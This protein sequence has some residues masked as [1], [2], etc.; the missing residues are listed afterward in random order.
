LFVCLI[1]QN[2]LFAGEEEPAAAGVEVFVFTKKMPDNTPL[3]TF[4][5]TAISTVFNTSFNITTDYSYSTYIPSAHNQIS[6]DL[7][8]WDHI[9]TSPNYDTLTPQ[10]GFSLYKMYCADLDFYFYIDYRDTRYP[11]SLP[12]TGQCADIWVW[13]DDSTQKFYYSNQLG[14]E[15]PVEISKG[16]YLSIW[17]LK[18]KGTPSTSS[19]ENYQTNCNTYLDVT[20]EYN[21]DNFLVPYLQ[22]GIVPNFSTTGYKI[23]RC[24]KTQG[25]PPGTFS[26]LATV[27]SSTHTY[28]DESVLV[29]GNMV[30]Y[31]KVKAYNGSAESGFTTTES[32]SISGFYKRG[33]NHNEKLTH[34]FILDQNFPNPFNPATSIRYFLSESRHVRIVVTNTLGQDVRMLLDTQQSEGVHSVTF[35]ATGLPSGVYFYRVFSGDFSEVKRMT[36]LR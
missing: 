8:G 1:F 9:A 2:L 6:S 14:V 21:I 33:N 27:S 30:A 4:S 22:W 3:Y 24:I 20:Q 36:Y 34:P 35:H 12:C 32:I 23:Y 28:L 26:L 10:I 13:Y 31:Y 29:N 5:M 17:E 25:Q 7:S 19:F 11:F 16:D 18:G 15:S